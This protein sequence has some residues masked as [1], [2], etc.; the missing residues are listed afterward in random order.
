MPTRSKSY[1][2]PGLVQHAKAAQREVVR[3]QAQLAL[4]TEAH[5]Q[6]STDAATAKTALDA[7]IVTIAAL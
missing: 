2:K 7:L 1:T 5:V 4:T 6:A 3:L